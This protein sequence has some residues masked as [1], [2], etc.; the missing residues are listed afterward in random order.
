[1]RILGHESEWLEV[2]ELPINLAILKKRVVDRVF[3]AT[4]PG[5]APYIR[6]IAMQS[7]PE[8]D[9]PA[10]MTMCRGLIMALQLESGNADL[11]VRQLLLYTGTD[12]WRLDPRF[13]TEGCTLTFERLDMQ[14]LDPARFLDSICAAA[15]R[16]GSARH[17][18][19]EA[20]TRSDFLAKLS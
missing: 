17:G 10:R 18:V 16:D 14:D 7:T 20:Q 5:I 1:M 8:P 19:A 15:W 4:A 13:E 9:T 2:Q 11:P 6:H 12:K 3:F